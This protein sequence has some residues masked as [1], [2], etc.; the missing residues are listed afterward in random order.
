MLGKQK[1]LIK[2]LLYSTGILGYINKTRN[3]HTLTVVLFH[4][5]LPR[6]DVR[7]PQSDKHWTVSDDYFDDCLSFFKKHYNVVRLSDITNYLEQHA[8]LPE[9]ALLITFDDGWSDNLQYA[10]TISANHGVEPLLFVTTSAINTRILSWQET[11]ISAWQIGQL[12]DESIA[13]I[14]DLLGRPPT[15]LVNKNDVYDFIAAIQE[16][17]TETREKVAEIAGKIADKLPGPPQML[18]TDELKQLKQEGFSL[19]THGVRH[20]PYTLVENPRE[21]LQA[22][23]RDLSRFIDDESVTSMSFPHSRHSRELIDMARSAG[24]REIF[25]GNNCINRINGSPPDVFSRYN[26]EQGL[27]CDPTGKLVPAEL[28]M[29]LFFLPRA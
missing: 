21:D 18:A 12:D 4:R 19:G 8:S 22:S 9:N 6:D 29:Q 28:A 13:D 25:S 5:V 16:S 27:A 3:K 7:W 10:V 2:K 23:R 24:Y 20:E 1:R 26:I 11:L 15:S 14:A 17:T